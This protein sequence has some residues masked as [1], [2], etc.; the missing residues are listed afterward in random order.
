[1]FCF[2]CFPAN[3]Y[4]K[5]DIFCFMCFAANKYMLKINNRNTREDSS[6]SVVNFEHI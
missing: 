4:S 6:V 5:K 1:M 3:L 2:M